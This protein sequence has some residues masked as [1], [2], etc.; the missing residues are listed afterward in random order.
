L[1]DLAE[2]IGGKREKERE[3]KSIQI[4]NEEVKFTICR[5]HDIIYRK[6]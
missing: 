6:S 2:A 4:G 3:K 1:D 5:C